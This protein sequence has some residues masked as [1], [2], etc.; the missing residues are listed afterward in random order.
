MKRR[1]FF[2]V[3]GGAAASLLPRSGWA[4]TF[5]KRPV[6]GLLAASSKGTGMRFYGG[7][8]QG[9]REFGYLEDREYTLEGRY[10]DGDFVRLPLLAEDLVRLQPSVI[11]AS[12]SAGALALKQRTANIP[13]VVA[14]LNDPVGSGLVVSE[15]RPG[16]NVT[17]I[18]THLEGLP[19]KQLEI[20]R[21]LVGAD[22]KIA[23]LFNAKN[24]SNDWQRQDVG[25]V[26][27]RLG[28]PVVPFGVRTADEAGPAVQMIAR[29][30]LSVAIVLTDAMMLSVRRQIAAYALASHLPT[31]FGWREHVEDGGLISYGTDLYSRFHRAA[32]FVDRILKGAKPDE[33]PIE[34]PTKLELVINLTTA[35]A[36]GLTVPPA[37]LIRADEVIE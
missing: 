35:K 4:Q 3:L 1:E 8:T 7:F 23:V 34:F 36:I 9:M 28:I 15:A 20:A 33:L 31:I 19:G 12:N 18:R 30:G 22:G 27:A 32:Y 11:I 16:M 13:I 37:L 14:S 5:P 21:E 26:A 17:G 6:I 10:A 29:E 2:G 24:P 25:A